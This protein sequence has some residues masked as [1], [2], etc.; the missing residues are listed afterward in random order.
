MLENQTNLFIVP[1]CV[2]SPWNF[3][4]IIGQSMII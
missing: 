2:K 1:K 3:D 4:A